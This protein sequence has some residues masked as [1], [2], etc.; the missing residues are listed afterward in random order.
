[1]AKRVKISHLDQGLILSIPNILLVK[2]CKKLGRIIYSAL[3]ADFMLNGLSF[4]RENF[5]LKIY[6]FMVHLV[7]LEENFYCQLKK[8]Q[9]A[10][11]FKFSAKLAI[12]Y[13]FIHIFWH[14]NY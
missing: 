6:F 12:Q 5:A 9:R 3:F 1:M 4:L 14:A 11:N 10:L 8:I 13:N 7:S 2:I